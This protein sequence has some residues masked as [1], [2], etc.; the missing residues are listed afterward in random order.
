MKNLTTNVK[1][2]CIGVYSITYFGLFAQVGIGTNNPDPSAALEIQSNNKGLLI[3]QVSL[4]G[5]DD[6]STVAAPANGLLV[7]NLADADNGT[8]TDDE[9]DVLKHN[10]YVFN[11]STNQWEVLVDQDA[12]L[13][14]LDDIGVPRLMVGTSFASTGND[15]TFCSSN[16]GSDIYQIYFPNEQFDR[17]DSFDTS[18]SEFTAPYSGY[19]LIEVGILLKSYSTTPAYGFLR[20][21]VSKPYPHGATPP[22]AN[23]ASFAFLNQPVVVS[24]YPD[25]PLTIRVSGVIHLDQNQTIR[26]LTRYIRPGTT[27]GFFSAI[28]EPLGFNRA[29]VNQLHI[30]YFPN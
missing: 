20:L 23:N 4:S 17:E 19:Y 18:T 5:I 2:L 3:P 29:D 6:L 8:P 11:V 22:G 12:L 25:E 7:Y 26:V 24:G 15:T 9:D 13:T 14:A 16:L 27:S 1:L 21:G 28:T 10:F 30:T